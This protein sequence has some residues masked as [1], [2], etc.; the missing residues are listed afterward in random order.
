MQKRQG[1]QE[2]SSGS[3]QLGSWEEEHSQKGTNPF[4]G[5]C[6]GTPRERGHGQPPCELRREQREL[7]AEEQKQGQR[8]R[9]GAIEYQGK[10]GLFL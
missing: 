1:H 8:G 2:A 10:T 3:F 6:L 7:R 4:P 9:W 5:A